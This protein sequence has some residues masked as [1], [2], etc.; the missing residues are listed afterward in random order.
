MKQRFKFFILGLFFEW[1]ELQETNKILVRRLAHKE[2]EVN[3]L[4]EQLFDALIEVESL[5]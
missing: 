3:H 1:G 4:N 2:D 5:K